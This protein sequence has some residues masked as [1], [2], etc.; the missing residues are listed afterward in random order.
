MKMY[1]RYQHEA[2]LAPELVQAHIPEQA[3][4]LTESQLLERC[5]QL[6]N[7][8]LACDYAY[9][10]L[11]SSVVND[12]VYD[13]LRRELKFYEQE[14]AEV[15]NTLGKPVATERVGSEFLD[16][17]LSKLIQQA[18]ARQ[19]EYAHLF[20]L[21][22]EQ[23][24]TL[25]NL[26]Q[27]HQEAQAANADAEDE[28]LAAKENLAADEEESDAT[29]DSENLT[30]DSNLRY[31]E[32]VE[33]KSKYAPEQLVAYF[34]DINPEDEESLMA[35]YRQVERN[36]AQ[37]MLSLSNVYEFAD[38]KNF[39]EICRKSLGLGDQEPFEL[40]AEP[41]LDGIA[42]SI[43]Y[44]N[45]KIARALTRGDGTKGYDITEHVKRIPNVPQT[46]A[47]FAQKYAE[48]GTTS[49]LEVRG[50]LI[51]FE[52][53]FEYLNQLYRAHNKKLLV[54]LRNSA[55]SFVL[56]EP[57]RKVSSQSIIT[58]PVTGEKRR[59]ANLAV[60][61]NLPSVMPI[62]FCAYSVNQY[63]VGD[64]FFLQG[65]HYDLL[66]YMRELGF[67]V[68]ELVQKVSTLSEYEQYYK[69]IQSK[70]S[71]L[72]FDIDGT[73]F[74]VN[75]LLSQSHIGWISN[76][77]KWAVAFKFPPAE[78]TTQL[79]TV[80]T[81]VGRMGTISPVA[82]VESCF[83]GGVNISSLSLY[84]HYNFRR[85][86]LH[87]GDKVV[88][89]R[90]GEVIPVLKKALVEQRQAQA[91][92]MQLMPAC[93]E[94]GEFLSS[95][96]SFKELQSEV[97]PGDYGLG[98]KLREAFIAGW[99][100]SARLAQNLVTGKS[101]TTAKFK[102][103][104]TM[105]FVG[106]TYCAAVNEQYC[107]GRVRQQ[108]DYFFSKNGI[109]VKGIGG[110]FVNFGVYAGYLASYADVYKLLNPEYR[111]GANSK[112]L[113][114]QSLY[115]L[116]ALGYYH[117]VLQLE[118]L[119]PALQQRIAKVAQQVENNPELAATA[120]QFHQE[121]QKHLDFI[122]HADKL[123][124]IF[125]PL[126]LESK[127]K[128]LHA[129]LLNYPAQE[130]AQFSHYLTNS[131]YAQELVVPATLEQ[132]LVHSRSNH[133]VET[134]NEY[135]SELEH[136]NYQA[137]LFINS[138][139]WLAHADASKLGINA[140]GLLE[141]RTDAQQ[142]QLATLRT[143]VAQVV[144]KYA[145]QKDYVT[146]DVAGV[147]A[148][149]DQATDTSV[150]SKLIA[151][152]RQVYSTESLNQGREAFAAHKHAGTG[153]QQLAQL[154]NEFAT[155]L[156]DQD[157][158]A[159][160][161]S[162]QI[163]ELARD[164]LFDWTGQYNTEQLDELL[165]SLHENA[166]KVSTKKKRPSKTKKDV[167][168]DTASEVNDEVE[169]DE[170]KVRST[171][172]T[173]V[174]KLR[175]KRR[176]LQLAYANHAAGNGD[177]VRWIEYLALRL[178]YGAQ[179]MPLARAQLAL[180]YGVM[181]AQVVAGAQLE[182]I[183]G[184]DYL[185]RW[186]VVCKYAL[187]ER[188]DLFSNYRNAFKQVADSIVGFSGE[189][190]YT[191]QPVVAPLQDAQQAA[192]E[193]ERIRQLRQ[194]LVEQ[195]VI[196][197]V[198]FTS[199]SAV[200][201]AASWRITVAE[202]GFTPTN[203]QATSSTFAH[204]DWVW[205]REYERSIFP[206]LFTE[207]GLEELIP[208][209]EDEY[210]EVTTDLIVKLFPAAKTSTEGYLILAEVIR[211]TLDRLKS[212]INLKTLSFLHQE[213]LQILAGF[214][215]LEEVEFR[216]GDNLFSWLVAQNWEQVDNDELI[217]ILN[218]FTVVTSQQVSMEQ[219]HALADLAYVEQTP[220]VVYV[221]EDLVVREQPVAQV[222]AESPTE[223]SREDVANQAT[224]FVDVATPS[225][226]ENT[227]SVAVS[228]AEQAEHVAAME[229]QLDAAVTESASDSLEVHEQ[230]EAEVEVLAAPA[231]C[232]AEEVVTEAQAES[233][234]V[235]IQEQ[236]VAEE[237]A[238]HVV[239]DVESETEVAT[240][241]EPEGV[242]VAYVS[243]EAA[244]STP[245]QVQELSVP[246]VAEAEA[247]S[248]VMHE[249]QVAIETQTS[250]VE[251]GNSLAEVGVSAEAEESTPAEV[252]PE[253]VA[254]VTT[255]EVSQ[256]TEQPTVVVQPK[257]N[258]V[259]AEDFATHESELVL[260]ELAQQVNGIDFS[261]LETT[262]SLDSLF[263]FEEEEELEP[264]PAK[265]PRKRR[266]ANFA[267]EGDVAV[268]GTRVARADFLKRAYELIVKAFEV[269][270]VAKVKQKVELPAPEINLSN[271]FF[272]NYLEDYAYKLALIRGNSNVQLEKTLREEYSTQV[273]F[274]GCGNSDIPVVLSNAP[275]LSSMAM[276]NYIFT[277]LSVELGMHRA[278]S[279]FVRVREQITNAK[280][281]LYYYRI[282]Q[283]R[284]KAALN[285]GSFALQDLWDEYRAEN[286]LALAQNPAQPL[287]LS[288]NVRNQLVR[289]CAY[290]AQY[291]E[292]YPAYALSYAPRYQA[293]LQLLIADRRQRMSEACVALPSTYKNQGATQQQVEK[294]TNLLV[295][296]DGKS[297]LEQLTALASG[298]QQLL[299][300]QAD[301]FA[302][303]D[304]KRNDGEFSGKNYT[305]VF[306]ALEQSMNLNIEDFVKSI[307]IDNFGEITANILLNDKFYPNIESLLE[308]D[309]QK[310]TYYLEAGE[311]IAERKEIR[312]KA[313]LDGIG[314][315][316]IHSFVGYF[317]NPANR[318]S[319]RQLLAQG[320]Q[321]KPRE[322]QFANIFKGKKVAITGGLQAIGR[323]QFSDFIKDSGGVYAASVTLDT[324]YLVVAGE[325]NPDGTGLSTKALKAK[326]QGVEIVSESRFM[327]IYNASQK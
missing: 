180:L 285:V 292:Q 62:R 175:H 202:Q 9:Y 133:L 39:V 156:G 51:M 169:I 199:N 33:S 197:A 287:Y 293:Y 176:K 309:A 17:E 280:P 79:E 301:I 316:L 179:V 187:L 262:T 243:E 278:G 189:G 227:A 40:C 288:L 14:Y 294:A 269:Q 186:D 237:P 124:L 5:A 12:F 295:E 181:Q 171:L 279:F 289:A 147:D 246:V 327:E 229:S 139:Q 275:Q 241:A 138:L 64:E 57:Y 239:V 173:S 43:V 20:A 195:D 166:V 86:N 245:E 318:A 144:A 108:I 300:S 273:V 16:P 107:G 45:G 143:R 314:D 325:V 2:V 286:L 310:L 85:L 52:E 80:V 283:D 281:F 31:A 10:G 165:A 41:K 6:R 263:G 225:T 66:M 282:A 73:V 159:E 214:L 4:E 162:E 129:Q 123:E 170:A 98:F 121:R 268:G 264:T 208:E 188:K 27:E 182:T 184:A 118:A 115:P 216:T 215:R 256:A 277:Q 94:C 167:A 193:L 99:G 69:N 261:E 71:S 114:Q 223:E 7:T 238:T 50:E 136:L 90:G 254:T 54:N 200:M 312:T 274:E 46:L 324:N 142:A 250:Q 266:S 148:E 105:E 21:A 88:I 203:L 134:F 137:E 119:V 37:Q 67:T 145:A 222:V 221:T 233:I 296:L 111:K 323:K 326:K 228:G 276:F 291:L 210:G 120:A 247:S 18:S 38:F 35:S 191:T 157:V 258:V 322:V 220:E 307:G 106:N 211:F 140:E 28:E 150:W 158:T 128:H 42:C 49:V 19:L 255:S 290:Y 65:T 104:S 154:L 201:E 102:V 131:N 206:P 100:E 110:A 265:P 78:A 240:E 109:D 271:F 304:S 248:A 82:K 183:Y 272:W 152:L 219:L 103:M 112:I 36:H 34:S 213:I 122:Q 224:T 44:E 298:F 218:L 70:R 198:R 317:N 3:Q 160:L 149:F 320:V 58:D 95:A 47:P 32:L 81:Q 72:G 146:L 74:K 13:A 190:K 253:E 141:P 117:Q 11:N 164:P 130:L 151:L 89:Y 249:E 319:M 297:K 168:E 91:Q 315:A 26:I 267:Q 15:V 87:Q 132:R 306:A 84:N 92:P 48:S 22:P 252:T 196:G 313:G 305:N 257:N 155:W 30:S 231:A 321:I 55:G 25:I 60:V 63:Q 75:D 236:P 207:T 163:A 8:I 303:T 234:A 56:R 116:Y 76:S 23:S 270:K 230:N 83:V 185:E 311:T 24:N 209:L 251:V 217:T 53:E 127:Y 97:N 126:D 260:E 125:A 204:S 135:V 205:Q 93:P 194:L 29:E 61:D 242:E 244:T 299:I 308:F 232:V 259:K 178:W 101:E 226:T 153:E 212:G 174:N 68:S 1:A 77:P 192:E 284:I 96:L 302:E 59:V 172:R 177:T 235:D 161:T 113:A